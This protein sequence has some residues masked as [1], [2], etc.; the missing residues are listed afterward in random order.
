MEP[1]CVCLPVSDPTHD[2]NYYHMSYLCGH[3]SHNKQR[4]SSSMA[5]TADKLY[6]ARLA[7]AA[8]AAACSARDYDKTSSDAQHSS[9]RC[10]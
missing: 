8:A 2:Q 3:M 9:Y 6:M 7:A 10:G 1:L 5:L 4:S